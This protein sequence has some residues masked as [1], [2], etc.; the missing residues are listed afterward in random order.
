[1]HAESGQ[2]L[3]S[4]QLL[5]RGTSPQE[6]VNITYAGGKEIL[7]QKDLVDGIRPKPKTK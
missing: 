4:R 1:M 7:T 6:I 5:L 3:Y 2:T